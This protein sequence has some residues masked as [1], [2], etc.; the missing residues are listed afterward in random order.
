MI[1]YTMKGGYIVSV[2]Y[3]KEHYVGFYI[4]LHKKYDADIIAVL[5]SKKNK[6]GYIK[7]IIRRDHEN[8]D[9]ERK[10]Q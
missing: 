5:R 1:V 8:P 6:Q 2:K 10:S 9:I 4:K 3:D 7:E